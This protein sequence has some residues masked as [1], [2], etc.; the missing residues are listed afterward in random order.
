MNSVSQSFEKMLAVVPILGS[1]VAVTYDVG[2]FWSVDPIYFGFFS[3]SEH[4]VFAAQA[5][6]MAIILTMAIFGSVAWLVAYRQRGAQGA[7]AV[8]KSAN[9]RRIE[10]GFALFF[11]LGVPLNLAI[12]NYEAAIYM[13]LTVGS[14]WAYSSYGR[15]S[16]LALQFLTLAQGLFVAFLIGVAVPRLQMAS[17]DAT[18]LVTLTKDGD[19]RGRVLRAGERGLLFFDQ[20]LKH[21]RFIKSDEFRFVER[22]GSS[23]YQSMVC[24]VA[25]FTSYPCRE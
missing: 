16:V 4:I 24:I 8:T 12:G 10:T 18:H 9:E 23:Q 2:Y 3:L 22:V 6:P 19:L 11:I 1:L 25:S 14:I 20:G 21:V 7:E 5:I 17:L 15:E 13:L